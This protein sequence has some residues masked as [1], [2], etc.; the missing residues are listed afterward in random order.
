MTSLRSGP[1]MLSSIQC[2]GHLR[3]AVVSLL[4]VALKMEWV[5]MDVEGVPLGAS[6]VGA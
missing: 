3:C 4:K 1:R 6:P 2:Q 5:Q